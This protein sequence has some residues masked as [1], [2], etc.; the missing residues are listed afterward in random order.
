MFQRP[1][2]VS[3]TIANQVNCDTP[4]LYISGVLPD[5]TLRSVQDYFSQFGE[6]T[7]SI[8]LTD[9]KTRM[10]KGIGFITYKERTTAHFVSTLV[11]QIDGKKIECKKA[12]AQPVKVGTVSKDPQFKTPKIFVGGLPKDLTMNEFRDSFTMFGEVVDCILIPDKR[13]D[14]KSLSR[15]FGFIQF[16]NCE[17]VDHIMKS[18]FN[19]KIKGKW[20]D[21][22]K[23][24]PKE[25][26]DS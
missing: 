8:L 1:Q 5:T 15:G 21:L 3:E 20:V 6:I 23:A 4:R 24:L 10:N 16:A 7:D 18:Y 12:K 9:H 13:D 11:H 25:T 14:A 19:I 2:S 22:K 17:V 26:C